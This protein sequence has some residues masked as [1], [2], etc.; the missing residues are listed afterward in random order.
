MKETAKGGFG[1]MPGPG[2]E[3]SKDEGDKI[4]KDLSKQ[5]AVL[6]RKL[7]DAMDKLGQTSGSQGFK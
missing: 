5:N 2:I 1:K 4:I 3:R 6:R 7:D